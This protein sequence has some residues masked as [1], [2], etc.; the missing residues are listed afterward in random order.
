MGRHMVRM[1]YMNCKKA[2]FWP[3]RSQ[4]LFQTHSDDLDGHL[5]T[6]QKDKGQKAGSR[7]KDQVVPG[8]EPGL[9][10]CSDIRIRS[11]LG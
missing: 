3:P 9:P 11:A 6:G 10:E 4:I 1:L 7:A 2:S 8:I 5:S